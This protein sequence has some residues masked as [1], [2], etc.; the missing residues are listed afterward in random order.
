MVTPACPNPALPRLELAC[1]AS[2]SR[3]GLGQILSTEKQE[4][5]V[6][7]ELACRFANGQIT[8]EAYTVSE[9]GVSVTVLG[10]GA[11]GYALPA[12]CFDGE[13]SPIITADEK[14][15]TVAYEGW[16]CRY[17]TNGSI[18]DLNRTAANRNGHYR[19]FLATAENTLNVKIE[20]FRQ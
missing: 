17:T 15:M 8:K 9:K 6:S 7:A 12:L 4:H 5:A 16:L 20:I 11:I 14:T 10:E 1:Q 13:A 18:Q 19:G 2:G 3:A